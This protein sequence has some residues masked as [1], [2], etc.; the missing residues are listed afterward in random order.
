MAVLLVPTLVLG[1]SMTAWAAEI[2]E[3]ASETEMEVA[4]EEVTQ[5]EVSEDVQVQEAAGFVFSRGIMTGM[6]DTQFGPSVKL[7]RGQSAGQRR[8]RVNCNLSSA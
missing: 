4:A 5:P 2:G 7:S 8:R 6:T 3:K 1:S